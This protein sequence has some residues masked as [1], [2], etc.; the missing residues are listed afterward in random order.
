MGHPCLCSPA[1]S[2][3]IYPI[4]SPESKRRFRNAKPILGP[5]GI[6]ILSK[7][8]IPDLR[9]EGCRLRSSRT[10]NIGLLDLPEEESQEWMV[11]SFETADGELKLVNWLSVSSF[12]SIFTANVITIASPSKWHSR[13]LRQWLK[14]SQSGAQWVVP[15][16]A[17]TC[18]SSWKACD[19]VWEANWR[20]QILSKSTYWY[21]KSNNKILK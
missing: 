21:Q 1:N 18:M 8:L 15:V 9:S 16:L 2:M 12:A 6:L 5:F 13:C 19:T 20:S 17:P 4:V 3:V 11:T 10:T 7:F 14:I